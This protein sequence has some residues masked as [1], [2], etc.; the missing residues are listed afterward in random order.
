MNG[1][2]DNN[3]VAQLA[4]IITSI[5]KSS[6]DEITEH[7]IKCQKCRDTVNEMIDI[8]GLLILDN[9]I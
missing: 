8:L 4:E 9:L 6:N 1:C 5:S 3:E 7:M 2:L